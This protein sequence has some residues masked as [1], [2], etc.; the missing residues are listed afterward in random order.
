[1]GP[2][3]WTIVHILLQGPHL[4]E[5][6]RR[7]RRVVLPGIRLREGTARGK[8]LP[9]QEETAVQQKGGVRIATRRSK[10]SRKEVDA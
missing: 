10:H 2:S 4:L 8:T 1:M 5:P 6:L 9:L 3:R 7:R